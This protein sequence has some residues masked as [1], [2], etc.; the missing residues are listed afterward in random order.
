MRTLVVLL[1]LLLLPI[2]VEAQFIMRQFATGTTLPATP[3]RAA[4]GFV[5]TGGSPGV[6]VCVSGAWVQAGTMAGGAPAWGDI[7]GT[8]ADQ[9]DLDTALDAKQ[10]TLISAT[11][12]KT[13]NG[14]SVLG[15]GDLV[16]TGSGAAWGDI[17][18]T[19]ADQTDLQAALD[20]KGTSNFSG[21][22]DDLTD[23]P[24]LGTAA[25]T[26][27]TDYATA[28][29]GAT[30]DS[31][32]QPAGNGSALTGLTKTQVGLSNVDNTADA[33]KSVSSAATLTTPR[34]INGVAF[35]GSGNI[36]VTAAADTLTGTTLAVL[37]GVNLTALNGS[38]IASG[39]VPTARLGS[40]TANSTT[41]LRGDS[42]W[43]TAPSVDT[44]LRLTGNVSTAANTTLVDITAM[45]F[46]A[47]AAGIYQIETYTTHQSPAA[48]T[49]FGI[50][51]NCA[52]TPVLV[53]LT[54]TSQLANAG[55]ATTWSSIANNAIAG[56]TSGMPTNATNIPSVGG[57]I[58]VAH[59][60]NAGTCIFRLRSE[61][62]AVT[63][64]MAQSVFLIRKIS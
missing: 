17:T 36:T 3:C 30:A 29:Q 40:G 45:S 60:T 14:D 13:I 22:Y 47:D 63:T 33:S 43:V 44:V 8:L 48:S 25:A 10:A 38:N 7:T 32:L 53:S 9:T 6:F 24:T 42:T 4:D 35:N 57:G 12:I 58:L 1:G 49:G 56:T 34:N 5:R 46:T 62:T 64:I 15:S 27:A 2:S 16:V 20:A 52:Q 39:T 55:T 31:A 51:I 19:L 61:T 54:G 28:A 26:A 59:A 23:K 11:N 41:F 21:D 37:S 18:G 50:G